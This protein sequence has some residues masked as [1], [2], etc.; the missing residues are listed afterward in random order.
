MAELAGD[1][2][3]AANRD[4]FLTFGTRM[5][6][7]LDDR[8]EWVKWRPQGTPDY[9]PER[10]GGKAGGRTIAP[11][12]IDGRALGSLRAT[13]RPPSPAMDVRPFIITAEDLGALRMIT[14][15]NR[16]RRA[17][18]RVGARTAWGVVA[19][20][21]PLGIGQALCARLRLALRD[22]GVPVWLSSPMVE[23]TRTPHG[24]GDVVTGVRVRRNGSEILVRAHRGVVLATGGFSRNEEMRR[25]YL[26]TPTSVDW[27][28]APE[29]GQNGDGIVA[30][31]EV[32]AATAL[33]NRT[34]GMPVLIAPIAGKKA[35]LL[36]QWERSLPGVMV[37][38]R[39]GERYAN[40]TLP[41]EEFW[42]AMYERE[43]T[44]GAAAPSWLIFDHR[45]KS[46]YLFMRTLPHV[47]FPVA[48][49]RAGVLHKAAT[50]D[51]LARAIDVPEATLLC[52]T[53]QYNNG[54]RNGSDEE[55][56]RGESAFAKAMGDRMLQNPNMAPIDH[57]PFYAMPLFPGD[58]STKGGLVTDDRARVLRA[59]G[60]V[61]EGLYATGNCAAAPAT[62]DSYPGAGA[63]IG[64][65]MVFGYVAAK[66]MT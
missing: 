61:I 6:Q 16:G 47:P 29:E 9:F 62:G 34:W 23:V 35:P 17:A 10:T 4:A 32:G 64:S 38:D 41:Y 24:D 7:E 52:T 55:Y 26:P 45:V 27:T 63:T 12:I 54:I 44:N 20:R 50:V 58:L 66:D 15:T 28:M 14:R 59:D 56:G 33:M 57:P 13:L 51:S 36:T 22:V 8:T 1:T 40:E 19:R 25:K 60:S 31:M 3:P 21:E 42:K 49:R 2:I 48:Y 53:A 30:G 65:A 18:L 37:V 39:T 5:V 43:A 11:A 46:R